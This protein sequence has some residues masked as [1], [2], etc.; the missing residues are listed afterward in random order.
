MARRPRCPQADRQRPARLVTAPRAQDLAMVHSH[1]VTVPRASRSRAKPSMPARRT[2]TRGRERTRHHL[3]NWR[4]SSAQASR[5][6]P[7]YP[8]R[9]PASAS[10]CPGRVPAG[11]TGRP[12]DTF[13][14]HPGSMF[15][16]L[17]GLDNLPEP[18]ARGP[19]LRPAK[20]SA[21]NNVC[22]GC[23]MAVPA[24]PAGAVTPGA[25]RTASEP[26]EAGARF[27]RLTLGNRTLTVRCFGGICR[28]GP[29]PGCGGC[30]LGNG[31][32]KNREMS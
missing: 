1:R 5:V 29:R 7:R 30:V 32:D 21:R 13:C 27:S 17:R 19:G 2:A 11:R 25:V 24:P 4:R 16:M 14:G 20:L 28:G 18:T 23:R 3:V 6:R 9:N 10:R 26:G 12:G 22:R 15:V 31:Q 8:A